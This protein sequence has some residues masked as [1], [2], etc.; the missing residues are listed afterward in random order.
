MCYSRLWLEGIQLRPE[1]PPQKKL[2]ISIRLCFINTY[3]NPKPTAY[4]N[5]NRAIIVVQHK[6][7][8]TIFMCMRSKAW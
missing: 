8:D 2:I 5:A 6:K 4:S 1:T 3:P 7:N